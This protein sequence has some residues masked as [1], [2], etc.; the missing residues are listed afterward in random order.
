MLLGVCFFLSFL[1][2]LGFRGEGFGLRCRWG[3]RF[4]GVFAND[5]GGI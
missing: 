1:E 2:D 4:E 3:G 5:D